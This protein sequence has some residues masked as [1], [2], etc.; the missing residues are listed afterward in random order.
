MSI[1][2]EKLQ[3]VELFKRVPDVAINELQNC[4]Q[5]QFYPKGSMI[6]NRNDIAKEM[7]FIIKGEVD[8]ID[9]NHR[10]FAHGHSGEF[11]GELGLVYSI[12]RTASVRASTDVDLC[13]LLKQDFDVLRHKFPAI[14]IEVSR[15]AMERLSRFQVE[16]VKLVS[17]PE[18]TSFTQEQIQVFQEVFFYWD[19][20]NDN[21]LD[22]TD[23]NELIQ[24]LSGKKFTESDLDR[25]IRMLDSDHDGFVSFEDFVKKIRTLVWFLSPKENK[26]IKRELK[27][28]GKGEGNE[29]DLGL[30]FKSILLGAVV[31]VVATL[32]PVVVVW[33]NYYGNK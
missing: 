28:E 22:K 1:S 31:G 8:I 33:W 30:D 26:R 6:V 3:E 27:K 9:A 17:I 25:I 24:A 18:S 12:P 13:M 29:V 11:F 19:R 15:L 4:L 21:I 16:L 2:R 20:N 23:I 32:I 7:F 5:S 10:T 14:E